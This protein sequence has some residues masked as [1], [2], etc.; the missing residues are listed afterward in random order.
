MEVVLSSGP[1]GAT[2]EAFGVYEVGE[3]GTEPEAELAVL[4]TLTLCENFLTFTL[5]GSPADVSLALMLLFIVTL[6]PLV[7]FSMLSSEPFLSNLGSA[8]VVFVSSSS[9]YR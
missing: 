9:S 3:F 7:N 8:D 1:L 5:C 6:P 2:P 4:E